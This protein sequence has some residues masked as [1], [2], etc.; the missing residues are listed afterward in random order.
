MAKKP[1][2]TV[3][4]PMPN[5]VLVPT[6]DDKLQML[7]EVTAEFSKVLER[8]F[9]AEK[10]LLAVDTDDARAEAEKAMASARRDAAKMLDGVRLVIDGNLPRLGEQEFEAATAIQHN[11]RAYDDGDP[12]W[13]DR[14]SYDELKAVSAIKGTWKE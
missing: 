11:G 10:D 1:N 6:A 8:L 12:I 5:P 3:T 13:L 2:P 7:P 9:L 4:A 14:T